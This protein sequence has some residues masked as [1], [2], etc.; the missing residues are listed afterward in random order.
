MKRFSKYLL[1]SAVVAFVFS[2]CQLAT[3][4][5]PTLDNPVA[6]RSISKTNATIAELIRVQKKVQS[7]VAKNMEATVSLSDGLGAGSGV[8][9]SEDGLIL[10]AAHVIATARDYTVSFPS[11]R[12]AI[13]RPLGK[14]MHADA[15]MLK[16][17]DPGPWPFVEIGISSKVKTGD[18]AIVMGHSGGYEL[19]RKPPVRTGRVLRRRAK[20]LVTDAVLIGGDSGGPLFN[21]EGE[22][23]GIHSSIGD[24]VAENRHVTIDTFHDSWDRLV[25]GDIWG[26]LPSLKREQPIKRPV[27]GVTV[28]HAAPNA[29]ITQVQP[30]S[31]ADRIGIKAGDVVVEFDDVA[32][33]SSRQLVELIKRK[34]VGDIC[35]ITVRRPQGLHRYQIH[36]NQSK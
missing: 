10:T 15:A 14:H 7:V 33:S 36:L 29:K 20:Q 28:D 12:Q 5:K 23:I 24:T 3:A 19:G 35:T 8:I 26:K 31:P 30:G 17:V 9:V 1:H 11:G 34:E 18:W 4:E 2:S 21:L 22:L 32:I 16:M 27:I 25:K 13:A 6:A